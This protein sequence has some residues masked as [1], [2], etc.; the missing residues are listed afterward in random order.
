MLPA[1]PDSQCVALGVSAE[2]QRRE[3]GKAW[4]LVERFPLV[5]RDVDL[6]RPQ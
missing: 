5:P 3:K 1:L 4:I 2:V 6:E